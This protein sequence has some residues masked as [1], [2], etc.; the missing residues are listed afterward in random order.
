VSKADSK[1]SPFVWLPCTRCGEVSV[2]IFAALLQVNGGGTTWR[3]RNRPCE[4]EHFIAVK[5]DGGVFGI[6][7]Q[8][9]TLRYPLEFY[10]PGVIPFDVRLHL[11]TSGE[12]DDF[13]S[14]DFNGPII[15]FP[16]KRSFSAVEVKAI[17]KAT[18]GK[19]HICRRIWRLHQR[20]R[21]GW[22]IDH[23]IPHIG[24]GIETEKLENFRVA[25]AKCNLKKGKG[26]RE[27]A[28]RLGLRDLIQTFLNR[29][30]RRSPARARTARGRL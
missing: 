13:A 18:E 2:P 9:Y 20:G 29:D 16:R 15:V 25:C 8:R 24:G 28:L 11:K 6:I 3:C 10:D 14:F 12:D 26:F 23:V 17:W 1:E 19:C 27:A 5:R 21:S 4:A 22:H 7:Y 30:I